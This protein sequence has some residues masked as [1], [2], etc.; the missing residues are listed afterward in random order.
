M[1]CVIF[2]HSGKTGKTYI[3]DKLIIHDSLNCLGS[4]VLKLNIYIIM[5][6]RE[7]K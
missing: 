6:R 5:S 7:N 1:M 2:M 4:T 3:I